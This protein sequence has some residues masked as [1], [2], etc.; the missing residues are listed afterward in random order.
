MTGRSGTEGERVVAAWNE[1]AAGA[2]GLRVDVAGEARRRLMRVWA[3]QG[4]RLE[5]TGAELH[6]STL[7]PRAVLVTEGG[8][9]L[10]YQ[11]RRLEVGSDSVV[12]LD[13]RASGRVDFTA[14]TLAYVW[15]LDASARRGPWV[16]D[17]LG[18]VVPVPAPVWTPLRALAN[19][20]L[21]P[22]TPPGALRAGELM[23]EAVVERSAPLHPRRDAARVY[24]DAVA[25][26]EVRHRDHRF[27]AGELARALG[28]SDRALESAFAILGRTP[29]AEIDLRRTG[30]LRRRIG[31]RLRARADLAQLAEESGFASADRAAE[32]L[33][34]LA[35]GR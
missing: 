20:L 21:E 7:G 29:A 10:E 3:P 24:A 8:A 14:S 19:S 27:T 5:P 16:R 23:L 1:L 28:V 34:G 31:S 30:A 25:V 11:G 17:R 15:R 12:L 4:V 33:D 18:E 6:D 2:S 26:I 13:A 32:A 9:S 22:G 35:R